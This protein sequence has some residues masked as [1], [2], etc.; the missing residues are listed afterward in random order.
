[1]EFSW[2]SDDK[3][4]NAKSIGIKTDV[5]SIRIHS[6]M[7]TSNT[8]RHEP[9]HVSKNKTE[10]HD[11]VSTMCLKKQNSLVSWTLVIVLCMIGVWDKKIYEVPKLFCSGWWR[12]FIHQVSKIK[13]ILLNMV[14]MNNSLNI[15]SVCNVRIW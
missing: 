14:K 8:H 3:M 2:L 15:I 4:I 9:V 1:M 12:Q 10:S 5:L 11:H 6:V 13:I 7:P